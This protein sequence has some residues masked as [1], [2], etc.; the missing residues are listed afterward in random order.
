MDHA[1]VEKVAAA[2]CAERCAYYGDPPC[3][4]IAREEWA[5]RDCDDAEN[6]SQDVGCRALARAAVAAMDRP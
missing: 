6:G 5:L 3:W 2:I 1:L 4:R